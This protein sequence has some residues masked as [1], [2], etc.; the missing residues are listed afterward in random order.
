MASAKV[1]VTINYSYTTQYD[2]SAAVFEE[3]DRISNE[4]QETL[5]QLV[6]SNVDIVKD[7]QKII[8]NVM[9]TSSG[10][11]VVTVPESN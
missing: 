6:G 8:S 3:N 5:K 11:S 1:Q 10:V 4:A 7:D 9:V 2:D